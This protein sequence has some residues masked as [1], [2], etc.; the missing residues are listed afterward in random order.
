MIIPCIA[1]QKCIGVSLCLELILYVN[2]PLIGAID[3]NDAI[4]ERRFAKDIGIIDKKLPFTMF[5]V[6]MMLLNFVGAVIIVGT[7]SLWLLIP[8]FVVIVLFYYMRVIYISTSRD[9]KRMEGISKYP[10]ESNTRTIY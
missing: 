6:A 7:V 3:I 4:S 8:T 9:V 1:G 2:I 10:F 5:D